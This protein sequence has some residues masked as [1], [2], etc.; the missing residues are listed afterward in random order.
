MGEC[1]TWNTVY[2]RPTG[3]SNPI[4]RN[5]HAAAQRKAMPE[6]LSGHIGLLGVLSVAFVAMLRLPS[7]GRRVLSFLRDL[8]DFLEERRNRRL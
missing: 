8:E 2:K 4:E 7:F 5:R 6:I 1:H 3:S